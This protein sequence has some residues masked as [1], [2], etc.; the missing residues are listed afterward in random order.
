MLTIN[1]IDEL[2]HAIAAHAEGCLFR[3]QTKHYSDEDGRVSITT[4][5]AR[6]GCIPSQMQ[7]WSLYSKMTLCCLKGPDFH[8]SVN[9]EE[10]QALLQHYGWRSFYLD[11]TTDYRIACWFA[12]N[13]YSEN[14]FSSVVEDWQEIGVMAIGRS[15]SYQ[16]SSEGE[17]FLYVVSKEALLSSDIGVH[18]ISRFRFS[19]FD[20]RLDRQN[21]VMV[22]PL[23]TLPSEAIV[24]QYRIAGD[25]LREAS[26]E[27]N[28]KVLFPDRSQDLIYKLLLSAPFEI[29]RHI[30]GLGDFGPYVRSLNIPE[31]DY[32]FRKRIPPSVAFYKPQYFIDPEK[33][34]EAVIVHAPEHFLYHDDIG[35]PDTIDSVVR[36]MGSK[37]KLIVEADGLICLSSYSDGNIYLKGAVIEKKEAGLIS[38][39]GLMVGHPGTVCS[40]I[41][42]DT[43]WHYNAD[44]GVFERYKHKDDCPCNNPRKHLHELS[45]VRKLEHAIQNRMVIENEGVHRVVEPDT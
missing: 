2:E 37:N 12:S 20:S 44:S 14:R 35:Q 6:N 23:S 28:Q 33:D 26:I 42:A 3:G 11:F 45:I 38:I 24:A 40:A 10:C 41:G 36:L 5:F 15:A 9:L 32:V 4:S 7:K 18:D 34:M 8:D 19:D 22:G 27:F 43:G 25:V 17:G 30:D 13:T 31:Y 1:T 29:P 16:S 21:A 39:S